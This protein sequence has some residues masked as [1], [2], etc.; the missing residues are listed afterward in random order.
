MHRSMADRYRTQQIMT[1]SRCQLVAKLYD[2]AIEA[3]GQAR[4]AIVRDDIEER[5]RF[6]RKAAEIIEHLNLTL[7]VE[8]GGEIASNLRRLYTFMTRRLIDVDL[9]NDAE[10]AN[11]VMALLEPLQ[12][13]WHELDERLL[14]ESG[15]RARDS[16]QGTRA[17]IASPKASPAQCDDGKARGIVTKA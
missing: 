5:W 4:R 9:Y 1:A 15:T 7:D 11:E 6:N 13:A 12:K 14:R 16:A 17:D 3:L 2:A 10:A 8:R